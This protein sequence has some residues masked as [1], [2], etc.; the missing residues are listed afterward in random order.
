[1]NQILGDKYTLTL[2]IVSKLISFPTIVFNIFLLVKYCQKTISKKTLIYKIKIELIIACMIC[3]FGS[4][5]PILRT[6]PSDGELYE[7]VLCQ[8]QAFLLCFAD[9]TALFFLIS[10]PYIT[11]QVLRDQHFIES[12]RIVHIKISVFSW[13][14]PLILTLFFAGFGEANVANLNYFCWQQKAEI[15]YI[16]CG[17]LICCVVSLLALLILLKKKIKEFLKEN[18]R[19]EESVSSYFG[20]LKYITVVLGFIL[21]SIVLFFLGSLDSIKQNE[22]LGFF[23]TLLNCVLTY[24]FYFIV[25]FFFCFQ[26]EMCNCLLH[27]VIKTMR[28]IEV[29]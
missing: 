5:F 27:Q 19:E 16:Y 15:G 8:T 7:K 26:K 1:M 28:I 14:F 24:S 23:F 2:F 20:T 13:T 3:P 9:F 21:L 4:F 6:I 17:V 18:E 25:P 10:I 22:A 12:P 29:N 11:Y